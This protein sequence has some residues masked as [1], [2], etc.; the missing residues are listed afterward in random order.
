MS[1][2]EISPARLQAAADA[3]PKAEREGARAGC[4]ARARLCTASENGIMVLYGSGW[5]LAGSAGDGAGS[6]RFYVPGGKAAYP[7]SVLMNA[8]PAKVAGVAE[9]IM[10]VPTPDGE[11]NDLVFA[12]AHIAGC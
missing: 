6:C 5:H 2:L 1:E 7:S 12:A 4:R 11:V 9:L 10:V 3:I 8:I